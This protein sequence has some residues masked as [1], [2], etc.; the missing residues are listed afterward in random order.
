MMGKLYDAID[1]KLE[2]FIRHQHLF[3]VRARGVQYRVQ[4]HAPRDAFD[5]QWPIA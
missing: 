1:G 5:A 2:D 4:F 3:F